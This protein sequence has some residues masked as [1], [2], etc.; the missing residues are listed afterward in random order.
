[1]RRFSDLGIIEISIMER[2]KK[3]KMS[4]GLIAAARVIYHCRIGTDTYRLVL[5]LGIERSAWNISFSLREH[6]NVAGTT[7]THGYLKWSFRG[8][9]ANV[10]RCE[11]T[12][13]TTRDN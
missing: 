2:R 10:D 4:V 12:A 9:V 1:M 7:H 11:C 13:R 8:L 3:Y 5:L 6:A